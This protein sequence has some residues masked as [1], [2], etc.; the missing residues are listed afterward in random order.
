MPRYFFNLHECGRVTEDGEGAD[1]VD[2]SAARDRAIREAR[3]IIC[4]EVTE[5]RLCLS[6]RIEVHDGDGRCVVAVP[7]REAVAASG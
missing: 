3:A 5:G 4:A 7:F 1:V 6:C 2:L